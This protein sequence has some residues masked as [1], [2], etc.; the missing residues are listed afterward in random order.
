M[1]HVVGLPPSGLLGGLY[2]ILNTKIDSEINEIAKKDTAMNLGVEIVNHKYA[3]NEN[4]AEMVAENTIISKSKLSKLKWLIIF[5]RFM[6]WWVSSNRHPN[7]K[8]IRNPT[9]SATNPCSMSYS[10]EGDEIT[11]VYY[12]LTE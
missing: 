4:I 6:I 7:E 9:N 2:R 3:T 11:F 8:K 1:N 5:F 10:T 12:S